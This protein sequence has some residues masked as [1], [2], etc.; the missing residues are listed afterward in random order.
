MPDQRQ[1]FYRG[2]LRQRERP[3]S[4]VLRNI[5]EAQVRIETKLDR[6]LNLQKGAYMD[7]KTML[8]AVNDKVTR[9]TSV[10]QSAVTLLN[11]LNASLKAALALGD[12]VA[13]QAAVQA[14]SDHVDANTQTLAAAVTA[15]T[16]AA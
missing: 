13:I 15:N 11:E 8:D 12:P 14:I 9:E 2:T 7:L 5:E 4:E 16:P 3:L 10:V 1:S 6:I